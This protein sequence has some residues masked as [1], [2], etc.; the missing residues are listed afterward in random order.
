MVEQAEE[1]WRKAAD[2][3]RMAE[4]E[5]KRRRAEERQRRRDGDPDPIVSFPGTGDIRQ[6]WE[7]GAR[8]AARAHAGEA[9]GE[10]L[11]SNVRQHIEEDTGYVKVRL[12]SV[13]RKAAEEARRGDVDVPE[14]SGE[15]KKKAQS[16][17]GAKAHKM[18]EVEAHQK[19]EDAAHR[20]VDAEAAL[21]AG[22]GAPKKAEAAAQQKVGA[23]AVKSAEAVA[24]KEAGAAA[25]LT[26]DLRIAP[27]FF[28]RN[29]L[30]R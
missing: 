14:N 7:R 26:S 3:K 27:N 2:G 28:G 17:A 21:T 10:E 22:D 6:A 8:A 9:G 13:K 30:G 18:A 23:E 25:E 15:A 29:S 12:P 1:Q 20:F 16:N 5:A 4:A 24:R 19:A 11:A